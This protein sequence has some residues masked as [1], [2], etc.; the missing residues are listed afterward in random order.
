[1]AQKNLAEAQGGVAQSQTGSMHGHGAHQSRKACHSDGSCYLSWALQMHAA[2]NR[3]IPLDNGACRWIT[4]N[5]SGCPW[6]PV[7]TSG[8]WWKCCPSMH[9]L[10]SL[11]GKYYREF[12]EGLYALVCTESLVC[13]RMH[14]YALHTISLSHPISLSHLISLFPFSLVGKYYREF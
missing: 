5:A 11:V 10:F 12:W 2:G 14:W 3:W 1:M 8:K 4:M 6:I 9:S 7:H 13:T